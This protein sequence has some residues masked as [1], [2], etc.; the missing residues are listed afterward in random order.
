MTQRLPGWFVLSALSEPEAC[1]LKHAASQEVVM[2]G[3]R[4]V[5]G[6]QARISRAWP[7]AKEEGSRA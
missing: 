3:R 2:T 1:G 4:N 7:F 6:S 5:G